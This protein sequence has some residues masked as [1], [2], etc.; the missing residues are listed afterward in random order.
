MHELW[1]F[2]FIYLTVWLHKRATERQSKKVGTCNIFNLRNA[3]TQLRIEMTNLKALYKK[4]RINNCNGGNVFLVTLFSIQKGNAVDCVC[5]CYSTSFTSLEFLLV[6]CRF[7]VFTKLFQLCGICYEQLYKQFLC[8]IHLFTH[9][10]SPEI[11]LYN[12]FQLIQIC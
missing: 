2:L 6:T 7:Y 4:I 10:S 11:K 9:S 1:N 12:I 3:Y 5:V 8:W